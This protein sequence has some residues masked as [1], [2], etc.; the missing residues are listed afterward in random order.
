MPT[1]DFASS[2]YLGLLHPSAALEPWRSLTLGRPAALQEAAASR[3]TAHELA[4]LA[5]CEAGCL[6][7]S[8]FHLFWDL[9][10]VLSR[11]PIEIFMD[12]AA[13]AIVRWS[14]EHWAGRG[15][16]MHRFTANDAGSLEKALEHASNRPR[17]RPRRAKPVVLSD[18]WRPGS[19][20]QPPLARYAAL[21]EQHRGWLVI[22]DTQ[23]LGVHGAAPDA[24]APYGHG[25]G[26]SLR[27]HGL[28][29]DHLII[30]ASLAKGFG[31]PVA[32][33]AGTGA[34]L[35]RFERDS[36][37][38]EHMSAASMAAVQAARHALALNRSEGEHRRLRLW[39]G[40][41]RLRAGLAAAGW[42]AQGGEFPVQSIS[43]PRGCDPRALHLR[44]QRRGLF[45]VPLRDD[46]RGPRL[47]LIVT[48]VHRS[49]EI[50]AA[51]DIVR[52]SLAHVQVAA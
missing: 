9:L 20:R 45:A 21:A 40:V 48:A 2:L 34:L 19:L 30:G 3:T 41:R 15:V 23:P 10:G 33:L 28:R 44:L 14:A 1:L 8:T 38:R 50:E 35:E 12:D 37:S 36:A 24:L 5:G 22:D 13:Y 49:A 47:G 39:H 4:T 6:L 32:V 7:P 46:S 42:P 52:T 29:G 18:G 27:R 43:L 31:V 26:G 11:E 51:V 16:P 17:N 25:G